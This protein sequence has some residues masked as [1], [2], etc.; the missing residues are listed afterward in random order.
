MPHTDLLTPKE[1]QLYHDAKRRE[2]ALLSPMEYGAYASNMIRFPHVEYIDTLIMA[3]QNGRLYKSGVGPRC[4]WYAE[5]EG[6]YDG[7]WGHPVTGEKAIFNLAFSEPPR[8]G[9]SFH[10]SEHL[11]AWFLTRYPELHV[12]LASYEHNFAASWGA[13]ARDLVEANPELGI[14]VRNDA[15]ANAYWLV[16][17]HRGSMKTAG[18]GGPIT[19]TGRHFG[20]IDDLLKNAEEAM[21]KTILESNIDWYISTWKTRR[22]PHPADQRRLGID[23]NAPDIFCVDISMSTRWNQ[24][25]LNGWL[26]ENENDSWY[27]VNLPAL[28]FEDEQSKDYG[29]PGRCVIGRKPGEALCPQRFSRTALLDVSSSGEGQFWFNALYQGVPRVEQGGIIQRPFRYYQ[30]RLSPKGHEEYI[31]DT[32][33][34]VPSYKCIRFATMDLAAT[35]RDHSDYTVFAVWDV[36]PGPERKLLLRARYRMKMESADHEHK[37]IQWADEF[38]VK[39]VGIENKTFGTTLIQNMRRRGD[40]RV[41][42]LEA[43]TDKVTR[44][45]SLGY[46]ILE[47]KVY[48]P[49]DATWLE[50]WE[51]ELLT[52][53]NAPHDDQVDVAAYAALEYERIPKLVKTPQEAPNNLEEKVVEYIDRKMKNR[54]KQKRRVRQ[55]RYRR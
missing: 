24:A 11:P 44:A 55:V 19:G 33:E 23:P 8:H 36:T 30:M 48:F 22:E 39:Y 54:A 4:V 1:R 12:H 3:A 35:M 37:V 10:V 18:A 15:R 6:D 47:Q 2:L 41:R 21:S 42:P 9:K 46:L 29:D 32:G 20:I 50:E 51:D 26:S 43:D 17:G 31:L 16:K 40:V 5:G 45:L 52:F 53:P 28:A 49:S 14:E 34:L 25:D 13:K 27:F 7:H 38:N